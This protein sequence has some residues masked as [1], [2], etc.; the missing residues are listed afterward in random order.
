MHACTSYMCMRTA[1]HA[2]GVAPLAREP[3]QASTQVD[4]VAHR[5][6]LAALR[7]AD[8]PTDDDERRA[9]HAHAYHAHA[10]HTH[11]YHT[12]A[13]LPTIPQ[14]ARPV[15]TPM[16]ALTPAALLPPSIASLIAR[17][18]RTY[19]IHVHGMHVRPHCIITIRIHMHTIHMHTIHMHTIHMHAPP[20][21]HH[22]HADEV[23]SRR[24]RAASCPYRPPTSCSLDPRG[25]APLFIHMHTIC[26]LYAGNMHTICIHMHTICILY[27]YYMHT[28]CNLMLQPQHSLLSACQRLLHS[29]VFLTFE[30]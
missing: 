4:H 16:H 7:T 1:K 28:I 24:R 27:A 9:Y 25:S 10:C 21:L 13:Y 3:H 22:Q 11:A 20:A 6:V 18:A 26:I 2:R 30:L 8:N 15:A 23:A 14:K 5:R 17:A 29:R 19:G 12:H